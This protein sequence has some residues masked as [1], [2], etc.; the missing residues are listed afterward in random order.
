MKLSVRYK[1][2]LG[3]FETDELE[4]T[5]GA[6]DAFLFASVMNAPDGGNSVQFSSLDGQTK[7]PLSFK[8]TYDIWVRLAHA[9]MNDLQGALGFRMLCQFVFETHR[10]VVLAVRL[11]QLEHNKIDQ[12]AQVLTPMLE[13]MTGAERVALLAEL[14]DIFCRHCGRLYEDDEVGHCQCEN[15]E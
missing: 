10:T 9:L 5:E 6:C 4:P 7:A 3:S 11:E 1:L 8:E 14:A 13:K 15:D 2:E 12:A